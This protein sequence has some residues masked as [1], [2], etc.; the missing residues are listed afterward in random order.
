MRRSSKHC[1]GLW[2][3]VGLVS[4]GEWPGGG[5]RK[6]LEYSELLCEWV[7][8]QPGDRSFSPCFQRVP[9]SAP[10][11]DPQPFDRRKRED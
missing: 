11:L 7:K 9:F 8:I 10:V 1:G 6:P 5:V 2:R 4:G 3:R